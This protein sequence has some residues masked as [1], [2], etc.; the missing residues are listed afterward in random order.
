MLDFAVINLSDLLLSW[1][2]IRKIAEAVAGADLVCALYNPKSKK[3]TMHLK[4]TVSI[5]LN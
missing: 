2:V 3:R 1:E 4:E 5:L